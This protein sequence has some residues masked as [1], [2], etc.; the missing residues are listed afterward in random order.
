M[1]YVFSLVLIELLIVAWI[2]FKTHKISNKWPLLNTALAVVFYLTFR[3]LYQFNWEIFIFPVGFIII[4]FFLYLVKIMGAGDSKYLASLF[5]IIPLE[6]HLPYFE[7]LVLSTIITGA[8]LLTYRILKNGGKLKAYLI[9]H[10]WEGV[11]VTLQSRFSYAPVI[12][13]AWL[14][15]GLNIWR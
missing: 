4:G 12:F 3:D 9:N 2:D 14:I 8:F 5:L 1:A 11:K 7:K 6:F 10:Y 13:L 15:L